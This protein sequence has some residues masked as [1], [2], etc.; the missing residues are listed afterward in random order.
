MRPIDILLIYPQLGSFDDLMRDIPLSL[1][2]A[3]TDSVKKGY[4][5]KILDLRLYP[6]SWKK[7]IDSWLQKGISLVGL[8][9]MTGNPIKTS[10]EISKYLKERCPTPIVWGGPHPT[11]LPRETLE[12]EYID[13]VIRDWGSKSLCSLMGLLAKGSITIED[14]LGLGYKKDGKIFLNQPQC[15]FEILDYLD[16]P[17]QL[18][19]INRDQYNRLS[20][21][22]AIFPIFTSMGCPYECSFCMSPAVYSKIK[23]KK[24]IPLPME[25]VIG[26]IEYLLRRYDF[27]RLQVYDDDSFIDLDRMYNLLE[28]FVKREFH[29]KVKLDFRGA[30][31]NELD[32]MDDDYLRLMVKANVELLAIGAESGSNRTL[33]KMKKG[34]TVDRIIRVNRKLARFPSLKPHYNFFCGVPGETLEDLIQTKE[35]LLRLVEDHPGAYLGVGADWKP[36]PGSVMTEIAVDTYG[37]QLPQNLMEWSAIDSFDARK[38]VHPWYTK[39]INNM[40]KLL[41]IAGQLLDCKVWDFHK[42]IGMAGVILLLLRSIYSPILKIRLKYNYTSILIEY[43]AKRWLFMAFVKLQRLKNRL[44]RKGDT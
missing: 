34:F 30:R 40:I 3:A 39:K 33:E 16:L 41:Q 20:T 37:L 22:E 35:L 38:I 9:V 4:V 31:I 18:V 24:W 5:V 32:R 43:E 7:Q 13:F 17:Y 44:R 28:E 8:S 1:I 36:I 29:K 27:Q 42:M 11:V 21:G 6:H 19:D 23:G 10:L 12:N 15:N 25:Y 26:H 14:I 2:Y